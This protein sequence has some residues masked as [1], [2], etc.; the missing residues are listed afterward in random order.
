MEPRRRFKR[1]FRSSDVKKKHNRK[2]E[3]RENPKGR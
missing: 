3:K 2:G 1:A